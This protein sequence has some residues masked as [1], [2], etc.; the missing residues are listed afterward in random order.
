MAI[1]PSKGAGGSKQSNSGARFRQRKISVKQPLTI[2]KQSDLP[3]LNASN[4]LEPSQIHH[5]NLNSGQ[6]QRDIHAIETG[7]DKNEED[8]VH[9]QQVIN[10]AQKVLLGSQNEDGDKKK[11]G[12]EK[13][14]DALVYIPTPD[15]SRI[16]TEASKYYN[17]SSFR[18]PETYIKFSATVEDTVGVEY[19]MDEE[20]EDFLKNKLWKDYP[21][22]KPTKLKSEKGGEIK[23]D[24]LNSRKC[25]EVEFEIICDKL[26]KTIEEKQPFLSMDPS[27][28]LSFKELSA[29]IIEEFNNSNKDKPYVQLGSNLKYVSTTTLKEKLSKELSYEPFVTLFDKSPTDQTSTSNIRPIP[30]LLELFGEPIYDHWKKRKIERRGKQIHPSL[31]F[32]DPS[33]NEKDNDNDPYV[34]FRRREF[35]QARK[36]RRA[37]T[38]GAERIRLLQKSMH[39]ARDLI[40][41][42]C[43]RELIKLETWETDHEIFKLRG[44]AKNLKRIVGVKGDDYLFYPHKR[45]KI[46]KIKEEEEDKESS[47]VKRDKRSRYDSSR[48]ASTTSMPGSATIGTNAIHK[49]RLNNGQV[50]QQD[51]S[52]S[53]SQPY[54]KLPPSKIPDMGLVTVSLVLK[55]KNETIKRAVL[56]KLRKRKEQD[57]GYI[58]VTDDPYQPFFNIA[59]NNKF[60]N[61]E[62][63]HIPYSSIAATSF[64]EINTTNYIGEKLKSLLEEGK[65]PLPGT[66]TF[67][68][69]NGELIPSKPFPHLL[70]LMQERMDNS[71]F[72]SVNYIAQLLSNI[73]NNNFSAYNNGYGQQHQR[74]Y[75]ELSRDKSSI[76]DPIFR[77]RKRVGRFNRT[78]V[79]RRGLMK[80]PDDVIDDFLKFDDE[81]DKDKMDIDSENTSCTPDVYTSRIDEIKRLDSRW[82]F[83]DDLTEY[84]KGLQ[85]PFSL[86]PSRLNCISDDTQSIRFGSM[87]LSKSYDLLRESVH[88]RQ[89]ALLQQARMRSLQQ[90]QR[91]NKQQAAGLIPG[92]NNTSVGSN[93]NTTTSS[94]HTDSAQ[95]I[96]LS[97]GLN[98]QSGSTANGNQTL[99]QSKMNMPGTS[100]NPKLPTQSLQRSNTSSPLLASQTQ[101]FSQQQKFNKGPS[102][103]PQPQSQSQSQSPTNPAN[104]IH[105]SKMYNNK[106]GSNI[107]QSSS[108][109]SKITTNNSN[110]KVGSSLTNRK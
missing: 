75:Q 36:T 65:K 60:K 29:Y 56:E 47:R 104:Q 109:G 45:K 97:P 87:L 84:E 80:R 100:I 49:D 39:R 96:S 19:N 101:G 59:T 99:T 90:Q 67:R 76:S 34:C 30:K 31:K 63:N 79:D 103:Q 77:L 71:Q 26:E 20:D 2:Y 43:R 33:A 72:N 4:E 85:A 3:T 28:I 53:S 22:E 64:H 17:D 92:S 7:V 73:E 52:T 70:A 40:M 81:D 66:K 14:A 9:L 83:D 21:K 48:E 38:L 78:F 94:S 93:S 61:N 62:L 102:S 27:N 10:A 105:A 5:L 58:N 24:D 25:L 54:V 35:R 13:K 50:H 41:S 11:D 98:R 86:D 57:K 1:H 69:S 107:P 6:Q 51:G 95:P 89:Q 88:Q 68:G 82:R 44:D 91:N 15:A 55:E 37:D 106:P 8:E 18:E 32:E 42:V 74:Q 16:W 108:K 12:N 46:A 23:K 110:N